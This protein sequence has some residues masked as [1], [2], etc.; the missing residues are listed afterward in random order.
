MPPL[1]AFKRKEI[2][3]C[4]TIEGRKL[5]AA[6]VQYLTEKLASQGLGMNLEYSNEVLA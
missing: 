1:L 6:L 4:K 3:Q 2:Y 5:R